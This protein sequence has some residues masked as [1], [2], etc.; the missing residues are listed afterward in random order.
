MRINLALRRGKRERCR[1]LHRKAL[2]DKRLCYIVNSFKSFT[3]DIYFRIQPSGI[4]FSS[5]NQ[6]TSSMRRI[7]TPYENINLLL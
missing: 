2:A 3:M 1:T 4:I 5:C 6:A 7:T